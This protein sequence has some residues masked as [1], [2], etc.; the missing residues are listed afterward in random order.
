MNHDNVFKRNICYSNTGIGDMHNFI[1]VQLN[2][3]TNILPKEKA[4]KVYEF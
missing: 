4:C 3:L 1:L 2:V